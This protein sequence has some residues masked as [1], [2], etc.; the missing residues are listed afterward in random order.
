[1]DRDPG[2]EEEGRERADARGAEPCQE[3]RAVE[4][5]REHGEI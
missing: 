1:V 4:A 3:G 2:D 5:E